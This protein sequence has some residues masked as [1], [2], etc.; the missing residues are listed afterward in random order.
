MST[1]KIDLLFHYG[2]FEK[3]ISVSNALAAMQACKEKTDP[4]FTWDGYIN[5]RLVSKMQLEITRGTAMRFADFI[6]LYCP[7][8]H[9]LKTKTAWPAL[10]FCQDVSDLITLISL[11]ADMDYVLERP[12]CVRN[13]VAMGKI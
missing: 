4:P 5:L 11:G 10:H 3:A 13:H 1:E 7:D 12:I 9:M 2:R 6:A 8:F